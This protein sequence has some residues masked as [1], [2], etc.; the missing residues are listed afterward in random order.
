MLAVRPALAAWLPRALDESADRYGSIGV[1]F[2][3]L[4]S[5]YTTSFCFL[6]ASVVGQVIATDRGAIGRWIRKP[7]TDPPATSE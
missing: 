3:Y 4:A 6:A 5:L 7:D 1:A 2:T